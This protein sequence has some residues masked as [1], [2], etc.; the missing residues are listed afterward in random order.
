MII[1]HGIHQE[2]E[3]TT[4]IVSERMRKKRKNQK[5]KE[6]QEECERNII[7]LF[8]MYNNRKW[9]NSAQRKQ[10]KKTRSIEAKENGPIAIPKI[11][12]VLIM[13]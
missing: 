11:R 9:K 12:M 2:K 4:E 10:R 6:N 1:I 8:D 7:R 13:F 3:R 5:R